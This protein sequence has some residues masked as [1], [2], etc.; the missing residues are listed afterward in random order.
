MA[1]DLRRR[2]QRSADGGF[3]HVPRRGDPLAGWRPVLPHMATRGSLRRLGPVRSDPL[4]AADPHAAR[5]VHG[6]TRGPVGCAASGGRRECDRLAPPATGGVAVHRDGPGL[7]LDAA[8]DRPREPRPLGMGRARAGHGLGLAGGRG[9]PQADARALRAVRG[10]PPLV[11]GYVRGRSA[12]LA[13]VPAALARVDRGGRQWARDG[14]AL[15]GERGPDDADPGGGVATSRRA[16][17]PRWTG[18]RQSRH[19]RSRA[20]RPSSGR[21]R[22][23]GSCPPRGRSAAGR[24]ACSR[25]T[26]RPGA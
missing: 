1:V 8:D 18:E 9:A 23:R 14:A 22:P 26:T 16:T 2:R 19:R 21:P 5:A 6:A 4:P 15:L 24:T 13:R 12:R 3:R 17:R 20:R 7:A 25:Q 10:A 11:V